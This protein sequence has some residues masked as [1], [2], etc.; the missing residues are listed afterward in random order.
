MKLS[1][2][3]KNI[4]RDSDILLWGYPLLLLVPNVALDI[5]EQYTAVS[6]IANVLLPAGVYYLLMSV[7]RRTGKVGLC[8]TVFAVFAAFQIV[9]LFLY[10]ES[11]IAVDMF[12]NVATTNVAEASELLGNLLIAI[13]LICLL[14]IPPIVA[15]VCQTVSGSESSRRCRR[16][17][18]MTGAA[19]CVAGAA[20]AA[21]ASA[22]GSRID[23]ELFP[24]NVINNLCTAVTR[25]VATADYPESS[26]DFRYNA[27]AMHADSLKEVYVLV[28]GETSRA[29]NWQLL[30]Y[31][32]RP[33][34]PRLSRRSNIL[35]FPKALSESNT[36]HKSVPM[37]LSPVDASSFGDS[38]YT[39]RSLFDAFNDAG[40]STAFI[41]NQRR[42]RSFIDYFGGQ[43]GYTAFIIDDFDGPQHDMVLVQRMKQYL[44]STDAR[45]VLVVL[46][47]YG[48][49]F[50]YRERYP[51]GYAVFKP[52]KNSEAT[53]YN[54]A[55]L[56]NAYDNTI[57]YTDMVLDSIVGTLASYGVPAAMLYLS[58][59]GEDIFDDSRG[60]FL[61]ASPVATYHQLH[62][63][64]IL[65]MSDAYNR[66]YPGK[67]VAARCNL[68]CNVSSS[69]SAF[70]TI[71]SLAGLR[72]PYFN[73]SF[74]LV[75]S[76]YRE[77]V[78]LF[79]NDYLEGVPLKESGLRRPDFEQLDRKG[80]SY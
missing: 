5:T 1:E 10:G 69:A 40:F 52:D 35:A 8:M 57:V 56:V 39:T 6:K 34:N 53:L 79:L 50:N 9:L 74:S 33:T 19:L 42:N 16:Y 73:P 43:A 7:C 49:H 58:D 38:I 66:L 11:I 54:R 64:M 37:I 17:A 30:G 63:P 48:S 62:V 24:L 45:K 68:S 72:T 60:R 13:A 32:D 61:H 44:D 18:R 22:S 2:L 76:A 55:Q 80:I 31:Y 65:W 71:I 27:S 20:C 78:R 77:P 28:V 12:I 59:H 3:I 41:S 36:T 46:H 4:F 15:S 21:V 23:R 75:D 47:C 25:T 70:H 67:M 51:Q 26:A 29:E 14:Y